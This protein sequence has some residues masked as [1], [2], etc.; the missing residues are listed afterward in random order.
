M[1]K[2]KIKLS[3]FNQI[4]LKIVFFFILMEYYI[5]PKFTKFDNWE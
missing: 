2:N 3:P 1:V 4:I 5:L